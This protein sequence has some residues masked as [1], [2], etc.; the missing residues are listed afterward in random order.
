NVI[1]TLKDGY[2]DRT[3]VVELEAGGHRVRKRSKGATFGPWGIGSLR[4]EI[5][6]LG[7]LP[8]RAAAVFPPVLATWDEE[9]G[10]NPDVGYEMPFYADHRDAGVLARGGSLAQKEIDEFQDTLGEAVFDRLHEPVRAENSLAEHVASVIEQ[11][12]AT[13]EK[14]SAAARLLQAPSI[15][16]N[17]KSVSGPREA[18]DRIR[19]QTDALAA[20]DALPCVRLHGDFFL[21]NILWRP[22]AVAPTDQAPRLLLIDPVSVAGVT[23]GPPV[24]DLVKYISYATGELL[25]LRSEWVEIDEDQNAGVPHYGY[26]IRWEDPGLGPFRTRDWHTRFR[27]AFE[28][29]HGRVNRRLYELIDGYFS[30]AMAVNTSGTQRRARLLK[31]TACFNAVAAQER[32][33]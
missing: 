26:R 30:A 15:L 25:A 18:F 28:T 33:D 21:E 32:S 12:W 17:G 5:S 7:S 31:A 6:F 13:L 19:N 14:D 1:R 27:G 24:F 11:A 10:A 8:P 16:L 3:E 20:L 22:A 4:R 23:C 2:W 9:G 29:R